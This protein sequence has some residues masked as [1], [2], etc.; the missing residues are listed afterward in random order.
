MM[1]ATLATEARVAHLWVILGSTLLFWMFGTVHDLVYYTSMSTI[2]EDLIQLEEDYN[3]TIAGISNED[4]LRRSRAATFGKEG[5]FTQIL[6]RMVDV[7]PASKREMGE[8][9]NE[10]FIRMN[11]SFNTRVLELRDR[12]VGHTAGT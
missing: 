10:A 1:P 3:S 9:I 11:T 8:Q 12:S 4:E 5:P 7:P 2:Q 6:R